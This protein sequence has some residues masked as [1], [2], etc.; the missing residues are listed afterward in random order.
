MLPPTSRAASPDLSITFDLFPELDPS[1]YK[2]YAT[3]SARLYHAA[4]GAPPEDWT[5]SRLRGLLVF[6]KDREHGAEKPGADAGNFWFRLVDRGTQRTVWVF[7]VPSRLDY[8][9]DKPF[10]HA[11]SGRVSGVLTK[12]G[13]VRL[14]SRTESK[15]RT[16]VRRRRGSCGGR[17]QGPPPDRFKA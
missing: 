11:F 5:S 3:A 15:V 14:N 13:I 6:G 4:F 1:T 10:F 9:L 17:S 16:V 2:V 12:G 8:T 7:K